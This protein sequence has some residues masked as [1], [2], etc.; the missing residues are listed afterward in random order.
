VQ[1]Q[2]CSDQRRKT[3]DEF[4]E[5]WIPRGPAIGVDGRAMI[6]LIAA[7]RACPDPRTAWGLT[8]HATLCLLAEDTARSPW[9]V[10]VIASSPGHICVEYLMP[11]A[12][13]PWPNAYVQGEA[14]SVDEA[15]AMVLTAMDRCGGWPPRT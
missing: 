7:L 12:T 13:A 5:E 15:V 1:L 8:S 14:R 10:K 2:R 4:Y 9:Y 6:D 3:L 11:A